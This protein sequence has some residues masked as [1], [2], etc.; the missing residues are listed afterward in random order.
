MISPSSVS[1]PPVWADELNEPPRLSTVLVIGDHDKNVASLRTLLEK[2]GYAVRTAPS[3][4]D[5]DLPPHSPIDLIVVDTTRS[6]APGLDLC[7][8]VR[9][10][11]RTHPTP[12]L[13]ILHDHATD[14]EIAFTESGADS[15]LGWP[16]DTDLF[17]ARVRSM[18]R[19]K[20]SVDRLEDS[21]TILSSLAQ[22]VEQRDNITGGHCDRMSALCVAMGMEMELPPEHLL[23]LHR[24]GYLHDIGKIGIPDSIL[25]KP[26]PLDDQEWSIMRSH[27]TKGEEICRPMHCLTPV[28]PIIRSHHERWDGSGYPDGLA[29]RDIPLLARVLQFADIYDA[30]TS[31]RTYKSA[32]P[33]TEAVSVM[34]DETNRG[35]H[36]PELMRL[37]LGLNHE[38]VRGA[39]QTN[40]AEWQDVQVMV[41]SLNNL[42]SSLLL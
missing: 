14:R 18:L 5:L 37:F 2:Q 6:D 39:A 24:G 16:F 30:L 17:S 1:T 8:G 12:V 32:M 19:R 23:A 31:A 22:A 29:G 21:D 13:V 20:A 3:A 4:H 28:L 38:D 11:P 27:T 35:W 33:P 7:R 26:G 40:A 34:Q 42:R 25:L 9:V 41:D 15:V 10:N 36:D